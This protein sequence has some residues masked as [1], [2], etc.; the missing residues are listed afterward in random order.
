[1]LR[2]GAE[3]SYRLRGPDQ[4]RDATQVCA[5]G[6]HSAQRGTDDLSPAGKI[7]VNVGDKNLAFF[8]VVTGAILLPSVATR[9]SAANCLTDPGGALP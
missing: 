2:D 8:L 4:N 7:L 5:C 6:E 3:S 1:M 9:K